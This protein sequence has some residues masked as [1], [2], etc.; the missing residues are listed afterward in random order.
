MPK[1]DNSPVK[2]KTELETALNHSNHFGPK[3]P[4]QKLDQPGIGKFPIKRNIEMTSISGVM[5]RNPSRNDFNTTLSA[6]LLVAGFKK[7][8][9]L[10]C[11]NFDP[12]ENTY[13][14]IKSIQYNILYYF[15]RKRMIFI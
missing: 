12:L 4:I 10:F 8:S 3:I 1:H 7:V 2:L 13:I 11:T 14:P 5:I 15:F 6:N 9:I